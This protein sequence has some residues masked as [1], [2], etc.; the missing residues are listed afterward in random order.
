MVVI[1]Y[2]VTQNLFCNAIE[3][4]IFLINKKHDMEKPITPY[5]EWPN[6]VKT[7]T[8][9]YF[10]PTIKYFKTPS[11]LRNLSFL[12]FVVGII[13]IVEP[14]LLKLA[15]DAP[16]VSNMNLFLY[17]IGTLNILIGVL[18]YFFNY[19]AFLWIHE[20]SSWEER[21]AHKSKGKHQRQ[22]LLMWLALIGLSILI[23][24]LI[25]FLIS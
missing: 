6:S 23:T 20:H 16:L 4:F 1:R 19:K 25:Q 12:S 18:N 7:M 10:K 11:T 8:A 5:A 3:A 22:Y 9:L 21:F 15:F 14:Y 13:C 17:F 24:Y 2:A